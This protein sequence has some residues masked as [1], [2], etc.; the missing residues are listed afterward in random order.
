MANRVDATCSVLVRHW[1]AC[2]DQTD[3]DANLAALPLFL[4]GCKNLVVLA[5]I[6]YPTRLWCVM[7]LFTFVRMGHT[8]ERITLITLGGEESMLALAKFDAAKA[9]C[10]YERDREKLLA[11][12]ESGFGD[13]APFNKA[14]RELLGLTVSKLSKNG[15]G[16]FSVRRL[17]SRKGEA[18][19]DSHDRV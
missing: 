3:I 10:F 19:P 15:K 4:S 9:K 6:T 14:V 5:G 7:E 2:I 12:V 1:Q 18:K 16:K 17:Y 8:A 11:V 13:L